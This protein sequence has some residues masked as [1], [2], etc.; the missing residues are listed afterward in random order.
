M[1]F[2]RTLLMAGAVLG[3]SNTAFA[4]PIILGGDDLNEHGNAVGGVNL[5]GWKYIERALD[6]MEAQ[7]TL[8][9]PGGFTVDIVELGEPTGGDPALNSAA[10]VLGLTTVGYSGAAG[11]NQFFADLAAGTVRPKII[12]SP[13]NDYGQASI[14]GAESGALAA[15][16]AA[17]EAFVAAGGGLFSHGGAN[18]TVYSYLTALLPGIVMSTACNQPVTLT[19]TGAAAF[20]TLTNADVNAGPCHGTFSG[21]LGGLQVLAVDALQRAMIIGGV[22]G[23][24]VT[25]PPGAPEPASLLLLGAALAGFGVRRRMNRQ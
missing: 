22:G 4:G 24:I 12:Y 23:S 18:G 9:P 14:D 20:P 1:K 7:V 25:P 11:I 17:I 19:A 13:G 2:A 6:S 5:L 3:M 21:N 8:T 10:A 16:A 15:N